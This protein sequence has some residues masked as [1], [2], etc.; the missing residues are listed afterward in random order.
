MSRYAFSLSVVCCKNLLLTSTTTNEGKIHHNLT[1]KYA[2]IDQ[3]SAKFPPMPVPMY[4]KTD[5]PNELSGFQATIYFDHKSK[6]KCPEGCWVVGKLYN[7][8]GT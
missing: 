6:P 1:G 8:L 4:F 5:L 7:A 2:K 3:S